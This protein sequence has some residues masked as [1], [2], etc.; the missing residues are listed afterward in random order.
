MGR[1]TIAG[2]STMAIFSAFGFDVFRSFRDK[3]NV[4]I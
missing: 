2:L 3:A 4:I 1:Q